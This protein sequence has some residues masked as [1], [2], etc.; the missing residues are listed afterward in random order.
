MHR[1]MRQ[2]SS[3]V[4][5]LQ[6]SAVLY[7][8]SFSLEI[9]FHQCQRRGESLSGGIINFKL[10]E[11]IPE[12][13]ASPAILTI[14]KSSTEDS[15]EPGFSTKW[16]SRSL[17]ILAGWL[18]NDYFVPLFHNALPGKCHPSKWPELQFFSGSDFSTWLILHLLCSVSHPSHSCPSHLVMDINHRTGKALF[19]MFNKFTTLQI[20]SCS[21]NVDHDYALMP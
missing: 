11:E 9:L 18:I 14:D 21:V 5:L 7:Y 2:W 4:I 1:T 8:G 10:P 13:P 3:I 20:D 17:R 16:R 15:V 19:L 6:T 12:A